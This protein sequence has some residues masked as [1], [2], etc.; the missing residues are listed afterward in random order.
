MAKPRNGVA[1]SRSHPLPPVGMTPLSTASAASTPGQATSGNT[2]STLTLAVPSAGSEPGESSTSVV[3]M[4][5]GSRAVKLLVLGS[6]IKGLRN[7][8]NGGAIEMR[9]GEGWL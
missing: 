1:R 8:G 7:E 2:T 9:T 6:S 3:F 4:S 5:Y